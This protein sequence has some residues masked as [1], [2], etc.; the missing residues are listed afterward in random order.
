MSCHVIVITQHLL[1]DRLSCHVMSLSL[2]STCCLIDCHVKFISKWL[3]WTFCWGRTLFGP[4]T[5]WHKA[6]HLDDM[7]TCWHVLW[8]HGGSWPWQDGPWYLLHGCSMVATFH[9]TF[10]F[11][12]GIP[13]HDSMTM[14]VHDN[15]VTH[16]YIH[17]TFH[18][19]WWKLAWFVSMT[20]LWFKDLICR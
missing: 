12:R 13:F 2:H 11:M 4:S 3:T 5:A 9:V 15:S 18:D 6:W 1:S 8:W 17:E 14:T 19:I 10:H 20:V 7:L 16:H